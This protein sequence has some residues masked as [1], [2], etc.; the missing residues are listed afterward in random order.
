LTSEE[1]NAES[2]WRPG[3]R[4]AATY[5]RGVDTEELSLKAAK[6]GKA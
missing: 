1:L 3:S 6:K 2:G 5:L 4:E